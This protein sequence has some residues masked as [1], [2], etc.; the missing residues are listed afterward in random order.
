M[1]EDY[2]HKSTSSISQNKKHQF[3]LNTQLMNPSLNKNLSKPKLLQK[4][5]NEK[6]QKT[7]TLSDVMSNCVHS[8]VV[9]RK[10]GLLDNLFDGSLGLNNCNSLLL[11]F[12]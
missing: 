2:L 12:F 6:T 10:V 5:M 7:Y 9:E 11:L 4:Y 3:A 1:K 8:N